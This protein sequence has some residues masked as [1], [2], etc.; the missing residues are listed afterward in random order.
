M[1]LS[2]ASAWL[3]FWKKRI[4][5]K[6]SKETA[7][8]L[9]LACS[10][11]A[12]RISTN[13]EGHTF[14]TQEVA[15]QLK[16]AER[17]HV[18][19]YI[20]TAPSKIASILLT[21]VGVFLFRT[22]LLETYRVPTGSMRPTI[23]EKDHLLV[24]KT[25][26]GINN[27]YSFS[28]LMFDPKKLRRGDIVSFSCENLDV[29]DPDMFF[30]GFLKM[31][32]RFVKRLMAKGG[33]RVFFDSGRV[34]VLDKNGK[35]QTLLPE[36]CPHEYLPMIHWG[37][38][39]K[40]RTARSD[41]VEIRYFNQPWWEANHDRSARGK[42][43]CIGPGDQ[44]PWGMDRIAMVNLRKTNTFG[45]K[46]TTWRLDLHH[47][48]TPHIGPFRVH[49][50]FS[51]FFVYKTSIDLTEAQLIRI[52]QALYTSRFVVENQHVKKYNAESRET[53]LFKDIPDG[54]YDFFEGKCFKVGLF[55]NLSAL[56]KY[57][58]LYHSEER[59]LHMFRKGVHWETDQSERIPLRFAY[60]R[61]GDLYV[62]GKP[63]LFNGEPN[64]TL[65]LENEKK[66]SEERKGYI[67]FLPQKSPLLPSGELDIPFMEEHGLEVPEGHLIL[68]GDNHVGSSDSRDFGFVPEKNIQGSLL[69]FFWPQSS[70]FG[71][72]LSLSQITP[73]M[74]GLSLWMVIL[75]I[76]MLRV[77]YVV[78]LG[79]RLLED[80]PWL[81]AFEGDECSS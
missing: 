1:Y 51:P 61:Y 60:F 26:F 6:V 45:S 42:L 40:R 64:L 31:K 3:K 53:T 81:E 77:F 35:N 80:K 44:F 59:F 8:S 23:K 19:F 38:R 50:T 70:I 25:A 37:G 41:D 68:L 24:S 39:V 78:R 17:S 18:S 57:H 73:N 22:L 28:Y 72:R 4:P 12:H 13:K 71:Q 29:P 9:S 20:R 21:L 14:E 49:D 15:I 65:F 43:N 27:P 11:L 33:D 7:H 75:A 30:L 47:H 48:P 63:V 5:D 34:Y 52:K 62:M 2:Q 66:R 74:Y 58:P 56:E 46:D 36:T 54:T 79:K 76:Y 55:G 67:P 69:F 32:K 16:K 10:R